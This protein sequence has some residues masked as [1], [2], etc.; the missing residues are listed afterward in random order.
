LSPQFRPAVLLWVVTM[1]SAQVPHT[2]VSVQQ[3]DA[4]CG[5]CHE[6]I[7]H[8]FLKTPMANASGRSADRVIT[9]SFHHAASGVEYQVVQENGALWLKY[10]RLSDP[11]LEGRRKLDYFLGSGHLGITYLYSLNGYLLES[12]V[13]YYA[14]SHSYDMKPGLGD[15]E[16]MPP[17]LPMTSGCM[18]CHMSGVQRETPGTVNHFRDLPF[19]YGGITCESC[20]GDSKQHVV[21]SRKDAVVNPM[22]LDP[23]RRDSVCISC[24]L[25]GDTRIEHVG[26]NVDDFKPGDRIGDYLSYF[27]FS[28]DQ[29][30]S[31]GVSEIEQL[32]F[33][34]CKRVSGDRMTCMNC[35]D[36]HYSPPAAEKAR[37]YRNKCLACHSQPKFSDSHFSENPDCTSCH[38]PKGTAEKLPHIAWT[39]HRIRRNAA[40][41]VQGSPQP[42]SSEL[43][44]FLG[45]VAIPRD[46]ALAYYDLVLGGDASLRETA[47]RKLLATHDARNRDL[48]VVTSLGYLA[49]MRGDSAQ[50]ITFYQEALELDP[51]NV[52]ATNNLAILLAR[53]GELARAETLWKS[54]FERNEDLEQPST[55]LALAEC[56]LGNKETATRVLE[57]VLF[58]SPD[59]RLARRKLLAIQSGE[60]TCS[61]R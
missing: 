11:P 25:E 22:K 29:L 59:H 35:H 47:W 32:S 3:A 46:L 61:P 31:R 26:R 37:F 12:P 57:R 20:H 21:N 6:N 53:S 60:D 5:N 18:R 39:D 7:F 40:A 15:A 48:P 36:P 4:V 10:S 17:A 43:V 24:H 30:T 56:M 38:M 23:E 42:R 51:S 52:D 2:V 27:V 41:A 19:L 9:G 13:A 34:K 44:P 50:A 33:S 54:T 45:E 14:Q 49:Q 58:Y 55:N 8:N 16:T 1:L 28:S